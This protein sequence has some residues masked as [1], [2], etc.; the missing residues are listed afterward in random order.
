MLE[1]KHSLRLLCTPRI[2]LLHLV[3]TAACKESE[4]PWAGAISEQSPCVGKVG[5]VVADRSQSQAR[6]VR[7]DAD[8]QPFA[9][10]GRLARLRHTAAVGQ[11]THRVPRLQPCWVVQRVEGMG[12]GASSYAASALRRCEL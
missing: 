12:L 6:L 3:W 7:A 1:L 11:K 10:L 4:R 2:S 8:A 5:K 9:E